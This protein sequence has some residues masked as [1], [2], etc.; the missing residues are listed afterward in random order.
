[1][2]KPRYDLNVTEPAEIGVKELRS[3]LADVLNQTSVYGRITYVTNNGRRI[4]AIV[5]V[6]VADSAAKESN[7]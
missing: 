2:G 5:P 3:T 6:P 4:A 1:M 7:R